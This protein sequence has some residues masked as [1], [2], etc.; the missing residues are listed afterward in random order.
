MNLFSTARMIIN[1]ITKP[2]QHIAIQ[3]IPQ[4]RVID[5]GGGGEGVI[6]QV[7]G[8]SVVAMDKYL[9]EIDEARGYSPNAQWLVADGTAMPFE[10]H[11]FDHATVFFSGMYMTDDV[12]EKVFREASRMLKKDGE[13]WIWDARM[14]PKG[15][16]FA[17]RLGVDIPG[18]RTINTTYGVRAKIQ[19]PASVSSQL[20]EAGFDPQTITDNRHWFLIKARK[21]YAQLE[22]PSRHL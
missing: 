12:K 15:E 21:P 10:S 1:A 16:V 7:G 4:G 19:T 11:C 8:A 20:R 2:K 14:A 17:I 3:E 9:S 5:I 13:L 6:A 22:K 18:N